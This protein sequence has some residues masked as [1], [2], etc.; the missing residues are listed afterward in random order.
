M[1]RPRA[2]CILVIALAYFAAMALLAV[3]LFFVVLVLA[4][5]HG[6]IL[7]DGMRPVVLPLAWAIALIAPVWPAFAAW[8]CLERV[9]RTSASGKIPT[10][11]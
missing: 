1:I 10:A 3:V 7:P 4:G 9:K 2:G 11:P 6:G 8:R 5:P